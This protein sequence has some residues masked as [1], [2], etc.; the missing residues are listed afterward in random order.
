M[1]TWIPAT[2]DFVEQLLGEQLGE[3][4]PSQQAMWRAIA[5]PIYSV[6]IADDP[7]QSVFVAAK[8]DSHVLYFEDLRKGGIGPTSNPM[9]E[10]P[11]AAS[12][13][14]HLRTH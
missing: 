9:A 4:S 2:R 10:S 13:S 5:V 3:I 7:S 8:A 6:A 12:S 11:R 1:S 14:T